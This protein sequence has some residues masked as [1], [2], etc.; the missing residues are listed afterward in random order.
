MSTWLTTSLTAIAMVVVS[1]A[2]I[3]LSTMI[4][5]RVAGLRSFAKISSFDFAMT[6]AIGSLIA[7]TLVASDPPLFQAMVG[8][9][10][11]YAAQTTVAVLRVRSGRV[12]RAVDNQPLLLMQGAEILHE[13]LRAARLTEADLRAKLREANVIRMDEVRA[14]VMETTGDVSVLHGEPAGPDPDDYLLEGVR[15]R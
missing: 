3:Y 5:T 9:A 10:A 15:R 4:L 2:A 11:I 8:L 1:A 7:T 14:V 6:V 12:R 13:N